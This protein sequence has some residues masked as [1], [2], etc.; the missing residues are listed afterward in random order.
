MKMCFKNY[1]KNCDSR[2]EITLVNARI[3]CTDHQGAADHQLKSLDLEGKSLEILK[4][5]GQ[6]ENL[7]DETSQVV[8]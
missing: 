4:E 8:A 1:V 2:S 6:T 3:T 5:M 7:L